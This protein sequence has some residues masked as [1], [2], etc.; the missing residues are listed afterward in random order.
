[1]CVGEDGGRPPYEI[2]RAA[3]A[4]RQFRELEAVGSLRLLI[5][6]AG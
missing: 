4:S 5:R 6:L 1:M 3:V 2:Y